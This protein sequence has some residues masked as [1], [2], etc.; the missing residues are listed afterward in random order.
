MSKK[1]ENELKKRKISSFSFDQIEGNTF[2]FLKYQSFKNRKPI[3]ISIIKQGSDIDT[4]PYL[5]LK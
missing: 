4:P 5:K 2:D 3:Q 1:F